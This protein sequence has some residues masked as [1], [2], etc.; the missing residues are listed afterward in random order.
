MV[1]TAARK[2]LR[3]RTAHIVIH[4]ADPLRWLLST[5]PAT[6]LNWSSYRQAAVVLTDKLKI[7]LGF[8]KMREAVAVSEL[9]AAILS[10]SNE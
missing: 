9:P 5:T 3:R 8:A 4:V 1:A 6:V 7:K 2:I 10:W